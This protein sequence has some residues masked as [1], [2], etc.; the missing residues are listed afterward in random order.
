MT[1]VDTSN[2]VD[3]V[4]QSG[5]PG[6]GDPAEDYFE[7]SKIYPSSLPRDLPG[8]MRLERS[9]DMRRMTERSTRRYEDRPI[10]PLPEA[11]PVTASL[12]SALAERRSADAF[13]DGEVPLPVL[14][15]LLVRSYGVSGA[16][17]GH[18]LRPTPSG[19]AL[20]PL[21][22]YVVPRRVGSLR[23]GGRYHFDPFRTELTDAG[24]VDTEA[25]HDALNASNIEGSAALTV[26][27]SASFWRSRF[28]YGQ[29]SLRFVLLEAGHLVQ[30]L[31]L[32]AAGHGLAARPIGGFYDAPLTEA[33]VDHNGV[34]DAPV[35]AVLIGP[36]A[37]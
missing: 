30:N 33:M 25:V 37:D 23:C 8:I 11:E 24:D 4:Y 27:V 7:A 21:D 15:S 16:L 12:A 32:L 6:I 34:D 3:V 20:Y 19:G 29:R 10:V 9:E 14:A 35:Y 18:A 13:S 26:L 22:V 28:K 17:G 2:L 31:L 36:P 5:V 1:E